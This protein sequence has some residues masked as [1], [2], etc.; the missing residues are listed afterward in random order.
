MFTQKSHNSKADSFEDSFDDYE[1]EATK[2][3]NVHAKHM[4]NVHAKTMPNVHRKAKEIPTANVR[5]SKL[6]RSGKHLHGDDMHTLEGLSDLYRKETDMATYAASGMRYTGGP[7]IVNLATQLTPKEKMTAKAVSRT[8]AESGN[9]NTHTRLLEPD[10]KC[11]L[12]IVS[13]KHLFNQ[14]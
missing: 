8:N 4:A 13:D 3:P 6:Q 12:I 2:V 7:N 5:V 1:K 11:F 14:R 9:V 10:G